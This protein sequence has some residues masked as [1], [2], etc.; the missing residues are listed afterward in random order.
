MLRQSRRETL[1][2]ATI[3]EC[4]SS[5]SSVTV[6]SNVP[7][8]HIF[9]WTFQELNYHTLGNMDHKCSICKAKMWLDE[10]KSNSSIKSPVF[11]TCCA[12]SKVLLPPL[13]ELPPFL[14]VLLTRTNTQSHLFHQ[15]IRLYNS[16]LAFTSIGAK[17]DH[18]V[19]STRSIY[20]FRIYGEMYHNIGTLLPDHE[21]CP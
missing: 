14:N 7:K 8:V 10:R 2:L 15:N 17:I 21:S 12:N 6:L 18:S 13:Q 1:A 20:T 5:G 3:S 19:T 11:M 4:S 9:P 16:A